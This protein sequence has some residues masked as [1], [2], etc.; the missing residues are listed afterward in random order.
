VWPPPSSTHPP[1]A[2][3]GVDVA[4]APLFAP[5]P[6]RVPPRAKL[7]PHPPS[8]PLVRVSPPERAAAPESESHHLQLRLS[9]RLLSST[10]VVPH[11]PLHLLLLQVHTGATT[12]VKNP[13]TPSGFCRP[14]HSVRAY[15]P[16]HARCH[17]LASPFLMTWT[18]SRFH[19]CCDGEGRATAC[20]RCAVTALRTPRAAPSA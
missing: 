4:A 9:A 11:P 14:T 19:H 15:R 10:E 7:S 8:L 17:T 16:K 3:K 6:V 1:C 13:I 5:S 18:T 20:M 12:A 2:I